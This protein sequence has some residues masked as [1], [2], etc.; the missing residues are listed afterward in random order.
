MLQG[1]TLSTLP[2]TQTTDMY[3][4]FPIFFPLR[5]PVNVPPGEEVEVC[6]WRCQG[7]HKIWYEWCLRRPVATAIHNPNG[8]SYFV[9]L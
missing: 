9:G 4:W 1:V 8:R 7:A 3:S 5:E 2:E 6:M